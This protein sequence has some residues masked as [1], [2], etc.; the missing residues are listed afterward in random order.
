MALVEWLKIEFPNLSTTQIN[1]ILAAH[2]NSSPTN[3]AGP[4]FEM[5]GLSGANALNMSGGANGQQQRGYNIYAE[6]TF[7]CPAYSLAGSDQGSRARQADERGS[8]MQAGYGRKMKE[9]AGF[10]SKSCGWFVALN[11]TP[12]SQPAALSSQSTRAA[13]HPGA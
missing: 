12:V 1:S 11:A 6:A 8:Q 2:P 5:N 10:G 13:P 9:A 7:V 3:R 4:F